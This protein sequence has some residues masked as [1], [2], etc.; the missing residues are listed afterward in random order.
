MVASVNEAL[1]TNPKDKAV[2]KTALANL[3][4][5]DA[6]LGFGSQDPYAYFQIG[7]DP[8]LAAQ[9]ATLITERNE[10]KKVKDFAKADTL[11]TTLT[12]LGITI[13]DTAEGTV[14]EKI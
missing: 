5:I 7:V 10:A 11:R 4:L 14:W 3:E 13:M 9:V 6:V 12:D 2:K 8:K 1:D